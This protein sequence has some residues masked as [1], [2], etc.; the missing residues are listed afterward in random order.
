MLRRMFAVALLLLSAPV[1]SV[2]DGAP[3]DRLLEG[4]VNPGYHD[5]PAWFKQSFLDIREDVAEAAAN[6]QR[7]VLYFYQVGCPYCK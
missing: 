4:M 2:D 3:E 1:W 7:V 5:Q 6:D